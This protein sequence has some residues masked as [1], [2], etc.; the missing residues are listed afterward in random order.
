MLFPPHLIEF[1]LEIIFVHAQFIACGVAMVTCVISIV[2]KMKSLSS[3]TGVG[4]G[5][6]SKVQRRITRLGMMCAVLLV[7]NVVQALLPFS[8]F[9]LPIGQVTKNS[10]PNFR[11]RRLSIL[12]HMMILLCAWTFL[13]NANRLR[14]YAI[15]NVI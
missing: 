10:F 4:T 14:L 12:D 3:K 15:L 11:F 9:H 2:S 8:I 7:F 1:T 5:R 13:R 6:R